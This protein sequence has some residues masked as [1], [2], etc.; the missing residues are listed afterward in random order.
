[1]TK[2]EAQQTPS[3]HIDRIDFIEQFIKYLSKS[4]IECVIGDSEF[5]GKKWINWLKN[6]EISY[7]MNLRP[8]QHIANAQG[9]MTVSKLLFAQL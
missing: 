4:K 1:M 3:D 2:Y 5:I 9:E 7:V 8:S 6:A